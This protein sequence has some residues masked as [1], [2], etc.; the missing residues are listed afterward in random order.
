MSAILDEETWVS[1]EGTF[2]AEG[3]NDDVVEI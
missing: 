1:K 3:K 2:E